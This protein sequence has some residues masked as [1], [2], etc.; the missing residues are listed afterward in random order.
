MQNVRRS[1][2]RFAFVAVGTAAILAAAPA[3]AEERVCR[4][5]IGSATVDNLRVPQGETCTLNGTMMEGTVNVE[6]DAVLKAYGIRVIG[7]S[8]PRAHGGSCSEIDPG[9]AGAS[10]SCRA[11]PLGSSGRASTATSCS[12][13]RTAPSSHEG[14][15]SG[16][17]SRHSRTR[18]D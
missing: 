18:A 15:W 16:A 14:T 17:T 2:E 3:A 13:T 1:I 9:S 8:R 7:T 4:G 11:V 12:T 10:R 5:T 6:S